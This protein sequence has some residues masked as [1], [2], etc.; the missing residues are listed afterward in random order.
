MDE[1]DDYHAILKRQ[2]KLKEKEASSLFQDQ[3]D[4]DDD[5]GLH[6]NL[7]EVYGDQSFV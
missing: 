2:S 4:N 3:Y 7:E 6:T 1:R 5:F